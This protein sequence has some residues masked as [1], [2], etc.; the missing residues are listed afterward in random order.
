MGWV[1]DRLEADADAVKRRIPL[2]V[3][4]VFPSI[5]ALSD[6]LWV[7][8]TSLMLFHVATTVGDGCP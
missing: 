2:V 5:N 8:N 4:V 6:G 7:W 1:T 3:I